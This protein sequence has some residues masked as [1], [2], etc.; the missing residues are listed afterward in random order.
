MKLSKLTDYS[1]VLL[2]FLAQ[3]NKPAQSAATLAE[4]TGIPGPTVAKLMKMLARNGLVTSTRGTAGGYALAQSADET[5]VADIITAI[6]G[7]IALTACVDESEDLCAV[8]S[9][10][11]VAGNW[12]SVN[13]AVRKALDQVSLTDMA[14]DWR[15]MFPEEPS[16]ATPG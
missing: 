11:G 16:E 12:D 4:A 1:V 6:E 13:R 14:P 9:M 2:S 8:E 5:S 10:C 7:P 3:S 15:A